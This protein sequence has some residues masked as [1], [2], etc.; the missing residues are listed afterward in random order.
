MSIFRKAAACVLTIAVMAP[1]VA[2]GV[3][4][5]AIT[6]GQFEDAV[7]FIGLEYEAYAGELPPPGYYSFTEDEEHGADASY[8]LSLTGNHY[9]YMDFYDS[10]EGDKY[11]KSL[12]DEFEDQLKEERFEGRCD[13]SYGTGSGY[14]LYNG[15]RDG[16]YTYGAMYYKDGIYVAAY[17]D[18]DKNKCINEINSFLG[19]LDFTKPD[20]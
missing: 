11:F 12:Y 8:G 6:L 15:V 10:S 16:M 13:Y 18:S 4:Y 7:E 19:H 5:D 17:T 3:Q 20:Q 14:L 1:T 2:C 9:A